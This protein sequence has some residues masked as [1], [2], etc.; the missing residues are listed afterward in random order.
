MLFSPTDPATAAGDPGVYRTLLESTRAIPWRIDWATMGFSYIGPQIEAL[1]GWSQSSWLSANDWIERI[2]E[3]DRQ[4]TVDFCIAQ[5]QQGI[6]HEADYR[7]LTRDGDYVWIRDV[8][9]VVRRE[10]GS[11]DSLVGFMFDITERKQAEDKILQL[12]RELE[13]LS[14]RDSLT[15]VANRR[16]FDTL[17]PVEWA[18]A[19]AT[20]EPLS[21]VVIDIDYFKQY[22][23]HY[24]H[25]QGDEC[26]RRVA[27]ALDEGASRSRDLCARLGGEEFVLLL[28]ATDEAAARNVAERCRKLLAHKALPHARSGVGR[29]VTV[30][31]GVGTIVPGEHDDPH[32]FLDRV[33]RRLYQAKSS[34]R[35]RICDAEA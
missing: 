31:A 12:Q 13:V 24:G 16:M 26:L 22:N 19:R 33:D 14:Y 29:T 10:D 18:K 35:D 3:E 5:S 4:K 11:V 28:P 32:V 6:D 2:H 8:V 1:L 30:S 9:H 20:G 7:A 27:R 17:Y 34:G 23:D 21:V 25:V 15:N